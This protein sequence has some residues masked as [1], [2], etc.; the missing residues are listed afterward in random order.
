[1]PPNKFA[2]A[3]PPLTVHNA[4]AADGRFHQDP[5]LQFSFFGKVTPK[6]KAGAVLWLKDLKIETAL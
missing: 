3:S 4:R 5:T 6:T 1:M 2:A